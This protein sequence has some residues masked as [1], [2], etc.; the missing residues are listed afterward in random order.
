MATL[1]GVGVGPGDPELIT[2][3]ALRVLERVPVIAA[4]QARKGEES[5]AGEIVLAV[6]G[7]EKLREKE[8]LPLHFPMTRESAALEAAW[9]EAAKQVVARLRAQKDV[10]FVTLGDP[11]FYSTFPY[12]ER[13]VR[14]LAPTAKI[15]VIPGVNAFAA[16]AAAGGI[17]VQ[18]NERLAVVSATAAADLAPVLE[19]FDCTVV[20][21]AGRHLNGV[22]AAVESAGLGAKAY[23]YERCG[24]PGE[25]QG[26]LAA[27]PVADYLS[28]VVVRK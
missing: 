1:Y 17:T 15:A 19:S 25:R 21:K 8:F 16:C 24:F 26:P 7:P 23:L 27:F 12:L 9:A 14:A 22:R 4:P 13:A 20:L 5:I 28:L 6:L 10:A 2:L 18:G 11:T 3:K